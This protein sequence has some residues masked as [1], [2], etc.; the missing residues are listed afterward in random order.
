[1]RVMTRV[2]ALWDG[3]RNAE[4]NL[5]RVVWGSPRASMKL[6]PTGRCGDGAAEG[7]R[8]SE[9][10]PQF[11]FFY[12]PRVGVKGVEGRLLRQTGE[13]FPAVRLC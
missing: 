6:A 12:P 13:A 5:L 7:C 1:M 4:G 8:E 10:V 3:V 2:L 9:G 11:S